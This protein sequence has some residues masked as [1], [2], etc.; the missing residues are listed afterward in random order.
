[1]LEW[2][3]NYFYLSDLFKMIQRILLISSL[4]ILTA[5]SV[6]RIPDSVSTAILNN[7]DM[8]TVGQGLPAY[9][10]TIDGL[11]TNYPKNAGLLTASSMLYGSY[12]TLFVTDQ[13]RKKQMVQKAYNQSARAYCQTVNKDCG[14]KTLK[15]D[16]FEVAVSK[17]KKKKDYA[18]LY[19]LGTSWVSVIQENSDDWN[20]IADLAKVQFIMEKVVSFEAT[21]DNGQ[22]LLYLGV[23][24]SLIPPSLGGKPDVA[25]DYFERAIEATN[26]QNLYVKVMYAKQYARMMFDQELH[27]A[28][29][30]SVLDANPEV[31]DLWLQNVYAQ[32]QAAILLADGAEYF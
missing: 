12:A 23:L 13:D 17:V 30:N 29:L 21:Y 8:E 4:L 20:A 27:D 15:F 7:P 1:M 6:S 26:G 3:L 32:K 19:Q 5:C 14:L 31:Q 24:N 9:L 16:A 2:A 28:L 22:A 25:K 11:V 10:L 18:A